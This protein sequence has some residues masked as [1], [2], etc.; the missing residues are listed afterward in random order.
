VAVHDIRHCTVTQRRVA[1][2]PAACAR[3][4][5]R[6]RWLR[7]RD[8][9]FSRTPDGRTHQIL[10]VA[11]DVTEHRG[12]LDTLNA[13]RDFIAAVLNTAAALVVV[14]DRE[15]RIIRFNH[16]CELVSG[17]AAD[18]V[19]GRCLWDLLIVPEEKEPVKAVFGR[20]V[21]GDFPNK[22]ENHWISKT[23]ERRLIAWSNTAIVGSRGEVAY[24][25]GT[26]LD[27]TEQRRAEEALRESEERLR[28]AQK[29]EAVGRLAG[30]IAHDFN[31]QLTVVLGYCDMLLGQMRPDD[32]LRPWVEEILKASGA[33]RNAYQPAAHLQPQ[34]DHV[35][36]GHQPAP[37]HRRPAGPVGPG[38]R[39]RHRPADELCGRPGPR[40]SRGRLCHSS[41]GCATIM[42]SLRQALMNLVQSARD[43]MPRGGILAIETANAWLD[44]VLCGPDA[45][46]WAFCTAGAAVPQTVTVTDTGIGMDRETPWSGSSTRSSRPSRSGRGRA[47]ACRW[48]MYL[49]PGDTPGAK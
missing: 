21:S 46:V 32:P 41:C 30:G 38:D 26:G 13:E 5:G 48:P 29:M 24:V 8:V 3:A 43:A 6:W 14:M 18:E 39:R 22:Y 9:P 2:P 1:V 28:Q 11:E 40:H 36:R 4:D 16:T 20:L 15:G 33:V 17:Y 7:C 10:G 25:V 35:P 27:V 49:T 23:G 34:R 31:N 37:G 45:P 19:I 12:V 47:S 44:E 42:R